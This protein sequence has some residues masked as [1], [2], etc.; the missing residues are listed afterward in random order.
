LFQV[1]R[2]LPADPALAPSIADVAACVRAGD[3]ADLEA[4]LPGPTSAASLGEH[5]RVGGQAYA[6]T[7]GEQA[8]AVVGCRPAAGRAELELQLHVLAWARARVDLAQALAALFVGVEGATGLPCAHA[9]V[10]RQCRFRGDRALLEP[11]WGTID[12]WT[13][14]R[15]RLGASSSP[16]PLP[17]GVTLAPLP[18]AGGGAWRDLDL[19]GRCILDQGTFTPALSLAA[20]DASGPQGYVLAHGRPPHLVVDYLFVA[21]A[22][23]RRGLGR[24]LLGQAMHRGWGLGYTDAVA[25]AG[26]DNAP[27]QALLDQ[28]GWVPL[29]ASVL[30][31]RRPTW[32]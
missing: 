30:R 6:V 28:T 11:S 26:A 8:L 16:T 1:R 23:R 4:C 2:L 13:W 18:G 10:L 27:V 32:R 21:E 29:G 22:C 9:D 31:C 14:R 24:W 3:L 7:Q 19:E 12:E 5:L 17:A 25:E 20:S 15:L